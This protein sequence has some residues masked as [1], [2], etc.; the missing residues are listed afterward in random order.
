MTSEDAENLQLV[1]G[2]CSHD[3][4]NDS[5]RACEWSGWSDG[6]RRTCSTLWHRPARAL[7]S[8]EDRV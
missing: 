7:M 1:R 5:C 2:T 3:G 4:L 8:A 6:S